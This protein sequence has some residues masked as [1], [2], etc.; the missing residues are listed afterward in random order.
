MKLKELKAAGGFV[1]SD[2]VKRSITWAN[3]NGDEYTFDIFVRRSSFGSMERLIMADDDRSKSAQHIADC[4]LI[5]ENAEP[6]TY[7]DA[8]AL[9]PSLAKAI[10]EQVRAVNGGD[11]EAKN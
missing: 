7:E 3:T 4:V 11:A 9:E 6:M 10:L 8:Y 2:H 1:S 5:G